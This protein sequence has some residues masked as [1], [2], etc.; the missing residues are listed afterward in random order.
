MGHL[1]TL[2]LWMSSLQ[3]VAIMPPALS[4]LCSKGADG[5]KFRLLL[6]QGFIE[7]HISAVP[8]SVHG[9]P[10]TEPSPNRHWTSFPPQ[11]RR[12]SLRG[13]IL[14]AQNTK[15]EAKYSGTSVHVLNPFQIL[16]LIPNRTYTERIFPIRS[17]G[18]MINSFPWKKIL[19]LA[20]CTLMG[21]YK[22]I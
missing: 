6:I 14:C 3:P 2:T 9:H 8:V 1:L 10:S 16:G 20:Y 12:L 11:E 21:L 7:K 22:I 15:N 18:K 19:F 5:L 17:K 4:W 13:D